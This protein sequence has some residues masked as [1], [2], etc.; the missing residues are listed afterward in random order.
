MGEKLNDN[1]YF[2]TIPGRYTYVFDKRGLIQTIDDGESITIIAN[3]PPRLKFT[4]DIGAMHLS[5]V[6]HFT[7]EPYI[8]I[9]SLFEDEC[10]EDKEKKGS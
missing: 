10:K 9:E 7:M 5:N 3:S 6:G 1:L 8:S 2:A 4:Q